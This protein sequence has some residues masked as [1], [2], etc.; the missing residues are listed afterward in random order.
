[1]EINKYYKGDVIEFLNSIPD[2]MVNKVITSPPYNI[3]RNYIGYSDNREE[4]NFI[5]W[6][7]NIFNILDRVMAKNGI[8]MYNFSYGSSNPMLPT[9]LLY[10]IHRN[11]PFTLA[12][13]MI[14]KKLNATPIANG[15]NLTRL[16]EFIFIIVRK[17]DLTSFSFNG[18]V[19]RNIIEAPNNDGFNFRRYNINTFSTEL[20]LKLMNIYVKKDDLVLDPFAGMGTVIR[21][22]LL[23][24]CPFLGCDF[25]WR[26]KNFFNNKRLEAIESNLPRLKQYYIDLGILKSDE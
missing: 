8:I 19:N 5:G 17:D 9:N 3:R 25:D 4:S 23:F 7:I 6:Q 13:T 1:M 10:H 22:C 24:G 12:D 20:I 14:W 21:A 18:N 15:R 11:T 16:T 26:Q 2:G